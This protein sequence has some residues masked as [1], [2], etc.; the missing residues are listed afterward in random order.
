MQT[1]EIRITIKAPPE[2]VFEYTIEPK[3][4]HLWVKGA[5]KETVDT[6][7][8]GLGTK[9]INNYGVLTVT[10]YD[11][12]KFFELTNNETE[13]LCSYSYRKIS[14][15]ETELIYFEYMKNGSELSDPMKQKS[16]NKLKEILETN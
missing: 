13:Y 16:F 8:I 6:Q 3:N 5:G 7:Q 4:T 15:Q 10:D 9:Y 2:E 14:D 1:N 11:R 12:D